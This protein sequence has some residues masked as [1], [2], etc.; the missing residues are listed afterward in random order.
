MTEA[1]AGASHTPVE[2]L[3]ALLG[4][5][6]NMRLPLVLERFDTWAQFFDLSL[7]DGEFSLENGGE[8]PFFF[9]LLEF[10]ISERNKPKQ[11]T[12]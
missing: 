4:S 12:A 6:I 9:L 1:E 2:S 3:N 8:I 11:L 5:P 10:I 7:C